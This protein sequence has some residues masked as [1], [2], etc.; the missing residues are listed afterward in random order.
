TPRPTLT[1]TPA[2]TPIPPVAPVD[3]SAST[4]Q[5]TPV[6]ID[7]GAND[8]VEPGLVVQVQPG[9]QPTHGSVTCTTDRMCIYTPNAGYVGADTFTYLVVP[10]EGIPV[11]ATVTVTVLPSPPTLTRTPTPTAV[12]FPPAPKPSV[13]PT[14]TLTPTTVPPSPAPIPPRAI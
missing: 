5:N 4:R 2:V 11:S 14:S 1:P 6:S 7:V 13:T 9:T 10:S 12:V 8:A 3:D